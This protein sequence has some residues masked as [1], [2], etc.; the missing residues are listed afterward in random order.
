MTPNARVSVSVWLRS[1]ASCMLATQPTSLSAGASTRVVES[2]ARGW[3]T[4]DQSCVTL[5]SGSFHAQLRVLLR[6]DVM[7]TRPELAGASNRSAKTGLWSKVGMRQELGRNKWANRTASSLVPTMLHSKTNPLNNQQILDKA[8]EQHKKKGSYGSMLLMQSIKSEMKQEEEKENYLQSKKQAA[9]KEKNLRLAESK[10]A[11]KTTSNGILRL[12][13]VPDT[14]KSQRGSSTQGLH[15]GAKAANENK[16]QRAVQLVKQ[17]G[18]I[19]AV[20]P[21][22]SKS[23]E[24]AKTKSNRDK[25]P[26]VAIPSLQDAPRSMEDAT[27]L[28]DVSQP[29]LSQRSAFSDAF[30][31]ITAQAKAEGLSSSMFETEAEEEEHAKLEKVWELLGARSSARLIVCAMGMQVMDALETKDR[32]QQKLEDTRILQVD[33]YYCSTCKRYSERL[34]SECKQHKVVRRKVNKR[35]FRCSKCRFHFDVLGASMPRKPCRK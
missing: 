14:K 5:S 15:R 27:P 19:K 10:M 7:S 11:F 30:A 17:S 4:C 23:W 20:D 33:A 18:G 29:R 34:T 3:W 22:T 28:S 31:E 12:P 24:H 26:T 13:S 16:L 25:L 9:L 8:K 21:N 6:T 2:R 32:V 35:W 1:K